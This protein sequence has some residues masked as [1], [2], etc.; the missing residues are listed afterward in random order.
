MIYKIVSWVTEAY[1]LVWLLESF[2]W[3]LGSVTSV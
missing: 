3:D 1:D 2:Q